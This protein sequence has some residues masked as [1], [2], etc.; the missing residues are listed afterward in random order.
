MARSPHTH[1]DRELL[2]RIARSAGGKAGYKQ[3]VRE[4]GL[5]GGHER[6]LLLE[7]LANMVARGDLRKLEDELW[8]VPTPAEAALPARSG[9]GH[10]PESTGKALQNA[11]L[12]GGREHLASGRLELHR[13]GYGFVRPNAPPSSSGA[14]NASSEDIFIPPNALHGAMHGDV[15]LVDEDPPGRDGRRSGRIARVLTRR[16]PTIVGIFHYGRPQRRASSRQHQA[17]RA[18][19]HGNFVQPLDER[20]G[21]PVEIPEGDEFPA[22]GTES[23]H[24]TIGAE[25]APIQC[26]FSHQKCR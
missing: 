11:Q 12:R 13:D 15:V 8:A 10:K 9:P 6:R 7:Q 22:P 1:S 23:P 16:N 24:R 18:E 4:L 17:D 25:A 21:G 2:A 3:L 20:L 26:D 5:G 14:R 19:P